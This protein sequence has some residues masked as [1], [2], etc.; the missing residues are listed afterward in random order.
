MW[1]LSAESRKSRL[2]VQSLDKSHARLVTK[3]G[4]YLENVQNGRRPVLGENTV[5]QL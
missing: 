4:T 3:R 1:Q 2:W 5:V